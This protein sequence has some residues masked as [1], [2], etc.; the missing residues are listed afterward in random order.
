VK[1]RDIVA[2]KMTYQQIAQAKIMARDCPQKK[3]KGCD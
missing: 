1:N 2:R 3:F